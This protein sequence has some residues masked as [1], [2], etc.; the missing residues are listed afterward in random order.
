MNTIVFIGIVL[1]AEI[2]VLWMAYEFGFSTGW[3][4][5]RERD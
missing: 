5:G 3:I 1:I 4:N 2:A